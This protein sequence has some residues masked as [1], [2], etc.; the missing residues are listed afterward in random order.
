MLK[1]FDSSDSCRVLL[2]FPIT[3]DDHKMLSNLFSK[4]Y[5]SWHIDFGF[6]YTLE[7][8][9]LE[10]LYYEIFENKKDVEIITYRYKLSRYLHKLGFHTTFMQPKPKGVFGLDDVEVVLIGGSADSSYKIIEIV[11]NITLYNLTLVIVQ[12]IDN[13]IVGDFDEIL[14]R[15]TN[16]NVSYAKH[17][18]QLEKGSIYLA[19]RDNHLKVTDDKFVLCDNQKYN[20]AK[21]S[22]SISYES[23]STHYKN[24]LLVIQECGYA[25]D[26]VDKLEYLKNNGTKIIIQDANECEAKSMVTSA[27]TTGFYHYRLNSEDMILYL[28]LLDKNIDADNF[29]E[30]LLEMI[31]QK[32]GY[33]FRS[34]QLSMIQRRLNIF[35]LKYGIKNFKDSIEVILFDKRMFREFFA[36]VSINVTELFRNSNFFAQ[37]A[38]F[39]EENFR[40]SLN[41][42]IWS[43]GCSSGEEVYSIAILLKRNNMLNKS[44]IYATDFNK[45]VLG[46]GKNGLFSNRCY[47]KA[48]ENYK[49]IDGKDNLD[50]YIIKNDN[51][52][53]IKQEI[54]D[55]ILFFNHNLVVDSSFNEFDI[56]VCKNVII[57]FDYELQKRVFNLFY[58][59]LKFGG[60]L[61]IGESEQIHEDFKDK[62]ENYSVKYKVFKKVA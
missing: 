32:Y 53:K 62:F 39:L 40:K 18:Q 9:I 3:T 37:T 19:P 11:K 60:F 43:A 15:Y 16:H 31:F 36:E 34:Y 49:F 41:M 51:F 14:Q 54:K 2:K 6:V 48:K 24:K 57:Y 27:L 5:T 28:K 23:F 22:I 20:F 1:F 25:S 29:I 59:S 38:E 52:V 4:L 7:A 21:P 44:I 58:N 55:K 45:T 10:M 30:I 8:H 47:E 42:K 61:I 56:I 33:D 50:N 26:G 35:M 46:E 13:E 12:H 17:N